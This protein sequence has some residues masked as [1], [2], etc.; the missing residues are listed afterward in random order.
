MST[1]LRRAL[2]E[3]VRD[4]WS[5]T[6]AETIRSALSAQAYAGFAKCLEDLMNAGRASKRAYE[7][8]AKKHN[9]SSAYR[10]AWGKPVG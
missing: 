6:E 5:R 2:R 8:C 4:I 7:E 9:I 3:A 10:T 1:E